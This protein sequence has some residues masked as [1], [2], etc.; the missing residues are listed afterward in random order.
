LISLGFQ[1][2]FLSFSLYLGTGIPQEEKKKENKV[3]IQK[4]TITALR[5][6]N[7]K[8]LPPNYFSSMVLMSNIKLYQH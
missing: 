3:T 2:I 1:S 7:T 8:E 4:G 5:R 6:Q